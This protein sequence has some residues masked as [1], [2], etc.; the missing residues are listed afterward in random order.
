MVR[1]PKKQAN[2]QANA[3]IESEEMLEDDA[4]DAEPDVGASDTLDDDKLDGA[5]SDD[6]SKGRTFSKAFRGGAQGCQRR[7]ASQGGR[8]KRPRSV[9]ASQA[10][11]RRCVTML[12]GDPVRMYLKEIGKVPCSRPPRR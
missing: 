2:D 5:L 9:V 7:A 1:A 10:Q 3:P 11:R 6:G 4:M 12:T 8:Q